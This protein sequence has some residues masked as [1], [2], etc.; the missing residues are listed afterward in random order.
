GANI[1][2]RGD[3]QNQPNRAPSTD[4]VVLPRIE[5][6]ITFK[7]LAGKPRDPNAADPAEEKLIPRA[8]LK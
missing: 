2:W 5:G 4:T 6:E 8:P 7:E 3:Q 1:Y